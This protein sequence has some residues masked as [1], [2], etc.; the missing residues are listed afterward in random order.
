MKPSSPNQPIQSTWK[1][2][3]WLG[4]RNMGKE[5]GVTLERRSMDLSTFTRFTHSQEEEII[6]IC[7]TLP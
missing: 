1:L 6:L 4:M 3:K 2:L 5:E 7:H